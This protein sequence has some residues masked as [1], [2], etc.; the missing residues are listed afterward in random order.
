MAGKGTGKTEG[1][2]Q[3]ALCEEQGEPKHAI[4]FGEERGRQRSVDPMISI[5]ARV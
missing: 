4:E 5:G 2:N 1:K 3:A